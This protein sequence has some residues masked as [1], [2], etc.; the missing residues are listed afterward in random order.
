MNVFL[1]DEQGE[2]LDS[3]PIVSI[4][5]RVLTAERMPARLASNAEAMASSVVAANCG[6]TIAARMAK[7]TA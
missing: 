7:P 4:A 2:P 1:A 3:Q 6:T 5:E